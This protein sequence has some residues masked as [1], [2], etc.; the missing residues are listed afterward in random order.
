MKLR[1]GAFG[2]SI[3][4]VFILGSCAALL[5][6]VVSS[7]LAGN[8]PG[9]EAFTHFVEPQFLTDDKTGVAI[10][11]FQAASGK[12]Q[13]SATN[14]RITFNLPP[15]FQGGLTGTSSGC[16]LTDA[17][18]NVWTCTIGTVNAGNKVKRFL[19]FTD[20]TAPVSETAYPII[21]CVFFDGG[22]SGAPGGG[23]TDP[24]PCVTDTTTVV[25]P[26]SAVGQTRA[27]DCQAGTA[28]VFTP[29]ADST[30][31]LVSNTV[32]GTA[33]SSTGLPCVWAFV[34]ENID[35]N[36]NELTIPQISFMGFPQTDATSPVL[37]ITD[38]YSRPSG[39]FE[40]L[41]ILV[42]MNYTADS[43]S[44][45]GTEP[46]ACDP[47]APPSTDPLDSTLPEGQV[48]CLI[49]LVKVGGGARARL[50]IMGTGGDPGNGWG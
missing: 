13:G 31:N 43:T 44:F 42:D 10:A 37:W 41:D 48:V 30:T 28:N 12:G 38:L 20:G 32:Q 25:T 50:L 27:G 22:N 33:A 19:V 21:G 34:G 18:E 15:G 8:K 47:P 40:N 23:G 7:G 35:T 45:N 36:E 4:G 1:H 46:P 9:A 16:T 49:D 24:I 2:R 5:L 26:S 17:V 39:P 14:V 6:A 11:A 29:L 3:V